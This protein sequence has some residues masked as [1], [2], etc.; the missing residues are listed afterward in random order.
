MFT[1][2]YTLFDGYTKTLIFGCHHDTDSNTHTQRST[3]LSLFYLVSQHDMWLTHTNTFWHTH[4]CTRSHTRYK[5]IL[6][7]M[8]C[9]P[10]ASSEKI[11]SASWHRPVEHVAAVVYLIR[12]HSVTQKHL[13]Y[14]T[15]LYITSPKVYTSCC[16]VMRVKLKHL[17]L[18]SHWLLVSS[19][20]FSQY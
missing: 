19:D 4:A 5:R 11:I 8:E 1:L 2:N 12:F 6:S 15:S 10:P 17:D 3:I 16:C 20:G 14:F 18:H 9:L 7:Y 13:V